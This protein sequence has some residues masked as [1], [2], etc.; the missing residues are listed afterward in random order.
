MKFE[1]TM[2]FDT[3]EAAERFMS[4]LNGETSMLLGRSSGFSSYRYS[5]TEQE[6]DS[7]GR[8]R[9]VSVPLGGDPC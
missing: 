7:R 1:I 5:A 6:R 9:I 8:P 3:R 2:V 4:A